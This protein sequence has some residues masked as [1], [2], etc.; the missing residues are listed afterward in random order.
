M[1]CEGVRGMCV[2]LEHLDA[3]NCPI[4]DRGRGLAKTGFHKSLP[5]HRMRLHIL[6]HVPWHFL[7]YDGTILEIAR[8]WLADIVSD[9]RRRFGFARSGSS[10][11]KG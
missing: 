10:R 3:E 2:N 6:A 11:S 5:R 9:V 8:T 4:G 7:C 1:S